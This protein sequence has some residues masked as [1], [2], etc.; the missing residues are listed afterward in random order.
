MVE[1]PSPERPAE[2]RALK[3]QV[4][5]YHDGDFYSVLTSPCVP[6]KR[7]GVGC[8]GQNPEKEQE[9]LCRNPRSPWDAS[10]QHG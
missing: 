6:I 9:S 7:E 5:R 2:R 3:D 8:L 10:S 4:A 1:L